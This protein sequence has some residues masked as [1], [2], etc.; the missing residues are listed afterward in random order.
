MIKKIPGNLVC[1]HYS[2]LQT[3]FFL[4]LANIISRISTLLDIY[5]SLSLTFA[6]KFSERLSHNQSVMTCYFYNLYFIF[7]FSPLNSV[8]YGSDPS[9]GVCS[10]PGY[11][12]LN[13]ED[14]LINTFHKIQSIE[15]CNQLCLNQKG[16]GYVTYYDENS[17]PVSHVCM[18][19]KFCDQT[20]SCTRCITEWVGCDRNCLKSNVGTLDENIISVKPWTTSF[21]DCRKYCADIEGCSWFT[22]FTHDDK[23]F[24]EHCFLLSEEG[25]H[26][27]E[28]DCDTCISGPAECQPSDC[29]MDIGDGKAAAI[30]EVN[31]HHT[32][33]ITA[34]TGVCTLTL[35]L[36][37]GG[38]SGYDVNGPKDGG[39]GGGSGYVQ[40]KSVT[41]S[42]GVTEISVFVGS[43][44]TSSNVSVNSV[45]TN[46][47]PGESGFYDGGDGYSGGGSADIIFSSSVKN[48]YGA[49][50]G[51]DG[52][53]GYGSQNYG[54]GTGENVRDYTF[55]S[56]VLTP[57]EGGV[58]ASWSGG[59]GGGV[60]V[61]G[62][63]P[64]GSNIHQ[65]QG[66]GGGGPGILSTDTASDISNG[67][68]G[69]VILE[70]SDRQ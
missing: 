67:L 12:C 58:P 4:I 63:G 30:T 55:D 36:V 35:L 22:Y 29:T 53:R 57:G 10:S 68:Q 38:G 6:L 1:F 37:G 34:G 64:D 25:G 8:C 9:I 54:G 43:S 33:T 44:G 23:N 70:L 49:G 59:G 66:F 51:Y 7:A 19:F 52:G 13:S 28:E 14:T 41:L 3:K 11:A 69:I 62:K 2:S 15:D 24:S 20:R 17:D 47:N 26:N 65:G 5:F 27:P 42:Q 56:F 48:T 21:K 16:C 50:G 31:R 61:N 18:L 39:A 45:V 46:A 32:I 40:Y 60:L